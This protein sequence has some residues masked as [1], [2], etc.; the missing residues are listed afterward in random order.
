[1]KNLKRF[2]SLALTLVLGL[3]LVACGSSASSAPV[4]SACSSAESTVQPVLADHERR[5]HSGSRQAW[6]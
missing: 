4:V 1:M 5:H 2:V 3:S 6:C